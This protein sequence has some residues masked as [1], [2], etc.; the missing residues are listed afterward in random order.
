MLCP[1]TRARLPPSLSRQTCQRVAGDQRVGCRVSK[2]PGT[3]RFLRG[4]ETASGAGLTSRQRRALLR[5]G[6]CRLPAC[7]PA[8]LTKGRSGRV[9]RAEAVL[10]RGCRLFLFSKMKFYRVGCNLRGANVWLLSSSLKIYKSGEAQR[11]RN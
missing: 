6:P 4:G 3:R 10:W 11:Q 2:M 5:K 9:A 7:L 1:R 8:C